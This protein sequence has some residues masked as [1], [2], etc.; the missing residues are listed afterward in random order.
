MVHSVRKS[1]TQLSF[2]RFSSP[3]E[4]SLP[5]TSLQLPELYF[6][7]PLRSPVLPGLLRWAQGAHRRALSWEQE[8]GQAGFVG[9]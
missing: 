4:V 5:E 2:Q 7:T 8:P 6:R 1:W 3:R 9:G